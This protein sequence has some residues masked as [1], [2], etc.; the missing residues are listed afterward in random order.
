MSAESGS[1]PAELSSHSSNLSA[2]SAAS[3]RLVKLESLLAWATEVPAAIL[4]VLEIVVMF[5]AVIAR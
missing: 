1:T 2:G 3:G 4:V 5:A